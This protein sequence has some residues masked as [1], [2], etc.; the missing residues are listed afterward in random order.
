[1]A[2]Q[3]HWHFDTP[4][5]ARCQKAGR[6]T[7][8]NL[9]FLTEQPVAPVRNGGPPD[10]TLRSPKSSRRFSK[11]LLATISEGSATPSWG[12]DGPD[13]AGLFGHARIRF[14]IPVVVTCWSSQGCRPRWGSHRSDASD[15]SSAL[16]LL[17]VDLFHAGMQRLSIVAAQ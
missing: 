5:P 12:G 7:S 13:T 9:K 11:W 1:M 4:H 15:R 6:Q 10:P 16:P 17:L 2:G 3:K 14:P 8:P